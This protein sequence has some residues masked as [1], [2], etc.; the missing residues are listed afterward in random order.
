MSTTL[1]TLLTARAVATEGFLERFNGRGDYTSVNGNFSGLD[2]PGWQDV[3]LKGTI[4][5]RGYRFEVNNLHA[6]ESTEESFRRTVNGTGGFRERLVIDEL[7][8]S[9]IPPGPLDPY[10]SVS[11]ERIFGKHT[12]SIR[13]REGD[14]VPDAAWQL[15]VSTETGRVFDTYVDRTQ[16][17]ALELVYND[18]EKMAEV[19]YDA[20]VTDPISPV[21][22]GKVSLL[23]SG[24]SLTK[25]IGGVNGPF[26]AT[27][28]I[29]ESWTLVS[30]DTEGDFN[31]D[32][33]LSSLD[34]A[35]IANATLS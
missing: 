21:S 2:N 5:D 7:D 27:S 24:P 23:T 32:G 11:L 31:G 35:F 9:D 13:L 15:V 18:A 3:N 10:G 20:D 8:L 30:T 26:G 1:L 4:T 6:P 17:V 22:F 12:L 34:L 19:F 25:W 33:E 16:H 28:G 29:I 14:P